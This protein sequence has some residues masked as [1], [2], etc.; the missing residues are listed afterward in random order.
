MAKERIL[1][2]EDEPI[3]AE[4]LKRILERLGYQV[5]GKAA[6]GPDAIRQAELNRPQMVLMDIRLEGPMDGIEVAEYILTHFDIPVSYLTAYADE[7]TL[8]RAKATLPFGYILKPFEERHLQ[9]TI[10]LALFR[11]KMEALFK[12]MGSWQASALQNLSEAV[13]AADTQDRVTFMNRT[14]EALTSL[15]LE[16]SF[17]K[18]LSQIFEFSGNGDG[19]LLSLQRQGRKLQLR[20][21]RTPLKDEEDQPIGSVLVLKEELPSKAASFPQ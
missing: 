8:E 3:V 12:K 18:P 20:F 2:V 14:A 1:I 7:D 9:T 16:A 6:N 21:A 19:A 15:S 13:V 5:V 10:E 4:D 17:G 11:H